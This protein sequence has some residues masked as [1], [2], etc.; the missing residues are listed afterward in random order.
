MLGELMRQSHV[1][2]SRCGLGSSAAL[3]GGAF[4]PCVLA[5]S[6]PL[7]HA[8]GTHS[9][10]CCRCCCRCC[11]GGAGGTDRLVELVQEEHD[12]ALAAG[13]P[14]PLFG[15]KITGGGCGG[16]HQR[17]RLAWVAWWGGGGHTPGLKRRCCCVQARCACWAWRGSAARQRCSVSSRCEARAEPSIFDVGACPRSCPTINPPRRRC[18]CSG[19]GARRVTTPTCFGARRR[20]RRR[21]GTCGC[22]GGVG[23]DGRTGERAESIGKAVGGGGGC[24]GGARRWRGNGGLQRGQPAAPGCTTGRLRDCV[25]VFGLSCVSPRCMSMS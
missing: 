6:P 21:L 5:C 10:T 11:H 15:A 16:E 3:R 17:R 24:G 12:A 25:W 20:G 22:C 14:P 19:T 4:A 23:N 13:Q 8:A 2:Y 7:G 9:S 1:S 18:C